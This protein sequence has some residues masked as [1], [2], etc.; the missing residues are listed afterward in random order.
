MA[1]ATEESK[2]VDRVGGRK[3]AAVYERMDVA[4][5]CHKRPKMMDLWNEEK[6]TEE[7]S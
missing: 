4:E 2:K 6:K 1:T 3:Y 5:Q 7:S